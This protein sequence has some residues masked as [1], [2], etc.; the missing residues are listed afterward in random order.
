MSENPSSV[1]PSIEALDKMSMVSINSTPI[2]LPKPTKKKINKVKQLSNEIMDSL[3]K[4]DELKKN[5][6]RATFKL[7]NGGNLK[8][9]ILEEK[10]MNVRS[11]KESY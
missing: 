9:G 7:K 10:S 2:I 1:L 5:S 11:I 3:S 6:L 8:P 4:L